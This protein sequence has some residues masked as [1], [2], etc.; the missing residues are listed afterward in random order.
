MLVHR[1]QQI[2][3]IEA[4]KQETEQRSAEALGVV[5][6][7]VPR[8]CQDL[9]LIEALDRALEGA[10]RS[11]NKKFSE[12]TAAAG[13]ITADIAKLQQLLQPQVS[14]HLHNLATVCCPQEG[15]N[16][17]VTVLYWAGLY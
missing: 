12:S 9:T 2:S 4:A 6:A 15:C 17:S 3:S 1:Q 7:A 5:L 14:G 16:L 13:I 10:K 8:H 11:A